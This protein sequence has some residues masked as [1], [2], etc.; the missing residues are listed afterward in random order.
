V[1]VLYISW[2]PK[3]LHPEKSVLPRR[4]PHAIEPPRRVAPVPTS[5][6]IMPFADGGMGGGGSG[7]GG[8][9]KLF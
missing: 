1:C 4:P 6:R 2:D 5:M 7:A 9:R 8:S 3:E